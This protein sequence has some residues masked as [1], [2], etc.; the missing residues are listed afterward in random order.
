MQYKES[1]ERM[2]QESDDVHVGAG[3]DVEPNEDDMPAEE[4]NKEE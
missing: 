1:S 2:N 3:Q 4:E